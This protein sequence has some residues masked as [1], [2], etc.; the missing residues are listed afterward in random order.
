MK[1]LF[2]ALWP[3]RYRDGDS[4]KVIGADSGADWTPIA[5]PQTTANLAPAP[6]GRAVWE[7]H[8][9]PARPA[10]NLHGIIV[11]LF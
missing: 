8:R 10:V 6:G 9:T 7:S 11:E 3:R 2:E 1:A 4:L 5:M